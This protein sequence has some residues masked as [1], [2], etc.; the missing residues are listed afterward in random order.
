M[1]HPEP[2]VL[3]VV[4]K[5]V[6]TCE[7]V[8]SLPFLYGVCQANK[9]CQRS[10]GGPKWYLDSVRHDYCWQGLPVGSAPVTRRADLFSPL[11]RVVF[12]LSP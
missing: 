10:G 6:D 8:S 7:L 11:S 1:T 2:L 9:A 5:R 12:I 3:T 4:N